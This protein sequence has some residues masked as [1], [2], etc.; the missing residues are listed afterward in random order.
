MTSI[1]IDAQ[2]KGGAHKLSFA[3][4][5]WHFYAGLFVI[6]FLAILAVT[7]SMMLWIA[8]VD[9]RDGERTAVVPQQISAPVSQQA[10]A[11]LA[12]VP[13]GTLIQ[14]VAPRTA[15]VAALFRVDLGAEATMV[16]VDPYGASV[17][18]AFPRR[19]G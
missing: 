8:W 7:G 10:E 6:P 12:A 2:P 19:S 15:D 1:D 3:A 17:V 4:W 18:E 11:A 5:R 14:Y 13:G 16:A 9:G